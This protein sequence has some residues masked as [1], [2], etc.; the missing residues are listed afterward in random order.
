MKA[1]LDL[2]LILPKTKGRITR[3]YKDI[4]IKLA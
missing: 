3:P 1:G 4:T 2:D